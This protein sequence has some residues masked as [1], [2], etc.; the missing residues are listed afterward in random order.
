M[1][2]TDYESYCPSINK[3]TKYP[4][5]LS[6][7]ENLLAPVVPHFLCPSSSTSGKKPKFYPRI[8]QSIRGPSFGK[9]NEGCKA[10]I[11]YG[12]TYEGFLD[13]VTDSGEIAHR[14]ALGSLVAARWRASMNRTVETD[15]GRPDDV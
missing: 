9:L 6:E 12:I 10:V 7:V 5:K 15:V 13:F 4:Y 8:F 2:F 3:F 1:A 14:I 11:I